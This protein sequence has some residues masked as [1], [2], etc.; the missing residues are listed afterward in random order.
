MTSVFD[1]LDAVRQKPE[2]VRRRILWWSTSLLTLV[3]LL[4]WLVGWQIS[5]RVNPVSRQATTE[6][7]PP[8]LT[9]VETFKQIPVRIKTGWQTIFKK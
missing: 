4:L 2:A 9:L 7:E 6:T 1:Y 8:P 3:V 5:N